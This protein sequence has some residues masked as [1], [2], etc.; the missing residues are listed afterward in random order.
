MVPPAVT[1]IWRVDWTEARGKASIL[2][3]LA[4]MDKGGG[5]LGGKGMEFRSIW[6]PDCCAGQ[7]Q[8]HQV[9]PWPHCL[10]QPFFWVSTIAMWYGVW[11]KNS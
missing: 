10:Q 3:D 8:R 6:R 5:E 7:L 9:Y 2:L 1:A 4:D 11:R